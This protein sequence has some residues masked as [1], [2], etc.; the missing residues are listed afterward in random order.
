M[1]TRADDGNYA[2]LDRQKAFIVI[3]KAEVDMSTNKVQVSHVVG[4]VNVQSRLDHVTQT[5][6]QNQG[7]SDAR[8]DE[9]TTLLAELT[10]TLK[11]V[12]ETRPDDA[13][14]VAKTA[15]L[16]VAEAMKAKPD[17][18][19]LSITGEGLKKAAEAVADIAPTII[20]VAGKIIAFVTS[21]V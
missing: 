8:K 12:A 14:R 7:W 13:D 4:Q 18:G 5:V 6:Q 2:G 10:K 21:L 11:G 16:V 20:G 1:K 19:F 3:E 17:S 15:E 9:L